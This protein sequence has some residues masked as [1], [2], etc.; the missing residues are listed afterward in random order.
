MQ[1]EGR[2]MKNMNNTARCAEWPGSRAMKWLAAVQ[3]QASRLRRWSRLLAPVKCR[4]RK[5]QRSTLTAGMMM[6][7]LLCQ[8]VVAPVANATG[9][10]SRTVKRPKLQAK[11]PARSGYNNAVKAQDS[12]TQAV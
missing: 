12:T 2:E 5:P 9:K 11:N 4:S 8:A 6:A 1:S 3:H 10:E 7:V